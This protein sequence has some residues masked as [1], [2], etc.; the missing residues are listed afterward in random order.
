VI[1]SL[2]DP[3]RRRTLRASILDQTARLGPFHVG[4]VPTY[5]CDYGCVFCALQLGRD[6][7]RPELDARVFAD[8]LDDLVALGTRQVSLTGGGEPSAHSRFPDLLDIARKSGLPH[9]ISTHGRWLTQDGAARSLDPSASLHVS[10]NAA[11]AETYDRIHRL[12]APG[13]LPALCT[14]LTERRAERPRGG[15][16]LSLSFIFCRENAGEIRAF[17]DMAR[18]IGADNVVY[19]LIIPHPKYEALLPTPEQID[20]AF[21]DL[22]AVRREAERPGSPSVVLGD[23]FLPPRTNR[24]RVRY[25]LK[26]LAGVTR[27]PAGVR[28]LGGRIRA[29]SWKTTRAIPCLEGFV[30][31]YVDSDGTVFACHGGGPRQPDNRMG[32]LN[33]ERFAAIWNGERYREF[34]RRTRAINV[35]IAGNS[36]F[37]EEDVCLRC[38]KRDLFT[39]LLVRVGLPPDEAIRGDG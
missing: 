33:G 29:W 3:R 16:I 36:L 7:A 20:A 23:N 24:E 26:R 18:R 11:T 35:G 17:Y 14:A 21:A 9:T 25:T 2:D 6:A 39:D 5:R 37:P 12:R 1:E 4:I 27:E 38:P 13:T 28:R 34:R 15:G 19:R 10:M 22:A 30:N 31:A 8:L 32:A